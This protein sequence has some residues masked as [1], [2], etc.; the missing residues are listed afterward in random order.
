[1]SSRSLRVLV[2]EDNERVRRNLCAFLRLE[3]IDV[4]CEA[5]NGAE[6]VKKTREFKP[7]V[8]LLDIAMPKLNG[9]VAA[10]LIKK[11]FPSTRIIIV[12][13]HNSP[14]FARESL[15]A[16]AV[17]YVLKEN[18]S[19]DLLPWLEDMQDEKRVS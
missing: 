13:Q 11:E 5:V 14:A 7:D 10:R 19:R 15:S 2:A 17:A 12:S 6:A 4:V 3:G 16:G 8:V 1:M 9:F 18:A